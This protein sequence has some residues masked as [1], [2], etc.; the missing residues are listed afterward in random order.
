MYQGIEI[1]FNDAIAQSSA[2]LEYCTKNADSFS[3]ITMLK[4]PYSKIP[5]ILE[6]D[7]LLRGI[8]TFLIRQVIG[9]REWPG[10]RM[11]TVE[12][13]KVLNQYRISKQTREFIMSQT[14]IINPI[15]FSL[16]E[17]ICF[18]RNGIPWLV[19]VSHEN[20]ISMINVTR[21]DIE[22]V[23]GLRVKYSSIETSSKWEIIGK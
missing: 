6:H 3:F 18:Y 2:I 22:F 21:K 16:P 17:D 7:D 23:V 15:P 9:L 19:T 10:T 4:R 11:F 8:S 14:Q 12:F 5:P 20:S 1:D 13:H